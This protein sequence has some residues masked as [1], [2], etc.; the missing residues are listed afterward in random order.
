MKKETFQL[1]IL[2]DLDKMDYDEAKKVSCIMVDKSNMKD[3]KKV[4]LKMS[5]ERAPTSPKISEIMWYAYL[6][7]EGM[8]S[9]DSRWDN[10]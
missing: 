10:I 3:N 4:R 2:Q 1:N 7:G 9:L 5:L 6:S 8:A